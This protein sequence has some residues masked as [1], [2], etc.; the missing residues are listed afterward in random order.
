[1]TKKR[2]GA[3]D[4]W[5]FIFAT[6]L[7]I[8]H[9]YLLDE[10]NRFE[11][12]FILGRGAIAVEFFLLTSG[13]LMAV[14]VNK[15]PDASFSWSDTWGFIKRKIM[16]FYP[17]FV[18]AWFITFVTLNVLKFENI[19]TV[20]SNLFSSVFELTLI[21]N[22]GFSGYRALGQTW[23]LSAMVISMFILY[24]IYRR[25]KKRFEYYIAPAIAVLVL[26]YLFYKTKS[27]VNPNK[28]LNYG[29]KSTYRAFA[30]ICLGVVCY[31]FC[32]KLKKAKITKVKSHL[33]SVAELF[34]YG[35]SIYYM[36]CYQ[37]YP[38]YF[39]YVALFFLMFSVTISFS[40]LSSINRLF[41]HEIFRWL[42]KFSL[43]PY[44]M[45]MVFAKGLPII[46]PNMDNLTLELIYIGL[47]FLSALLV[48]WI[49]KPIRSLFA[50][51]SRLAV[52]TGE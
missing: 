42:G 18:I 38:D 39:D 14:S 51:S 9:A 21:R 11:L 6:L 2:N 44:L 33:L 45:F 12:P 52:K 35:F 28:F 19:S 24:P 1:M 40:G 8:F 37:L 13:F 27:V 31:V 15:L 30:E 46:F 34:G 20:L 7:V 50:R 23:Y 22:A 16:G 10:E 17:A 43:Y 29:F 47:T 26:G 36:Q 48:M 3:I 41:D 5:R 4:F 49:E 32:Q 25:N